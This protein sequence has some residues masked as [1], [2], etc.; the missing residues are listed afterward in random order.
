MEDMKSRASFV[1]EVEGRLKQI[2]SSISE[3][4]Q[5]C[6]DD[7]KNKKPF[8]ASIISMSLESCP[9]GVRRGDSTHELFEP[10]VSSKPTTNSK[11]QALTTSGPSATKNVSVIGSSFIASGG[12]LGDEVFVDRVHPGSPTSP[13]LYDR[14]VMC[15]IPIDSSGTH[16]QD[17]RDEIIEEMRGQLRSAI[18]EKN[19]LYEEI[20]CLRQVIAQM[21]NITNDMVSTLTGTHN[22]VAKRVEQ[23]EVMHRHLDLEYSAAL[24]SLTMATTEAAHHHHHAAASAFAPRPADIVDLYNARYS[25]RSTCAATAMHAANNNNKNNNNNNNNNNI[26]N[27]CASAET[28]IVCE[29]SDSLI[30]TTPP[31]ADRWDGGLRMIWDAIECCFHHEY[32]P[33]RL[34]KFAA[35]F[36]NKI[37]VSVRARDT[38]LMRAGAAPGLGTSARSVYEREC[39]RLGLKKNT[40]VLALFSPIPLD[41]STVK[42]LDL[43]NN[44]LGDHGLLALLPALQRLPHL[45][46]LSLSNNG[47]RNPGVH[48]L[49][50]VVKRHPSIA[51]LDLSN[52]KFTIGR[53]LLV[54]INL[55]PR[56]RHVNVSH[57]ALDLALQERISRKLDRRALGRAASFRKQITTLSRSMSPLPTTRAAQKPEST[58]LKPSPPLKPN[59]NNNNNNV[60]LNSPPK[61]VAIIE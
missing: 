23:L 37:A 26:V 60:R 29:A 39:A 22:N 51:S 5:Q 36:E 49:I 56:I 33:S 38:F 50:E 4:K 45:T 25:A 9:E 53:E 2:R 16:Q 32:G 20:E 12:E 6:A 34:D 8:N 35:V 43:S 18:E 40:G 30:M 15:L 11:A 41:D 1:D 28:S 54:L 13:Q 31:E 17:D 27:L 24:A 10:I 14:T 7:D 44:F 58:A 61:T 59:N 21:S 46:T 52:N 57:T 42:S 55:N 48:E 3:L 19:D 47:L